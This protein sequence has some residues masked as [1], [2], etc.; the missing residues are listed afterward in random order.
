MMLHYLVKVETLKMHVNT[1]SAYEQFHTKVNPTA[2]N[3]ISANAQFKVFYNSYKSEVFRTAVMTHLH[4]TVSLK[5]SRWLCLKVTIFKTS[6]LQSF[7]A[8]DVL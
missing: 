8:A 7:F 4:Q 5:K 6:F 3:Y 2:K 1:I